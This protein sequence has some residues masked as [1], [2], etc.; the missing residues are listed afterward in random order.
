M[1][2][3]IWLINL[4]LQIPSGLTYAELG[5]QERP[6][7]MPPAIDSNVQYTSLANDQSMAK[8]MTLDSSRM[9]DYL[10]LFS[11]VVAYLAPNTVI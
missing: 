6:T 8:E 3:H 2:V 5:S 7:V 9:Y 4:F 1:P 11:L 10:V